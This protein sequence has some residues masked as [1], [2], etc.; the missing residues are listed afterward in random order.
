VP[1]QVLA[2][3]SA[4]EGCRSAI[5]LVSGADGVTAGCGEGGG[6]ACNG[7]YS[8]HPFSSVACVA[9]LLRWSSIFR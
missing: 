4:V 6:A 2:D 5:Q 8:V 9:E 3:L 1:L 7:V